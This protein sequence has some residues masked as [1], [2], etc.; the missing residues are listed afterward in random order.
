[1]TMTPETTSIVISAIGV[2]ISVLGSGL[3]VAFKAGGRDERII[4][5]EEDLR[6]AATKEQFSALKEDVAEIKG[7]FRM[8]LKDSS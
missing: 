3:V 5:M 4:R 2:F 1:M 6:N 7:M 8:V